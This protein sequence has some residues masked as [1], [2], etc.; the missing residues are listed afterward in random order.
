MFGAWTRPR[1][2]RCAKK[3][4]QQ[5]EPGGQNCPKCHPH[6]SFG[7]LRARTWGLSVA[8][9]EPFAKTLHAKGNLLASSWS[10]LF[11]FVIAVK[12]YRPLSMA[13][14]TMILTIVVRRRRRHE[15]DEDD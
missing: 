15:D 7:A 13:F 12:I 9:F 2:Q 6:P 14:E 1:L 5:K 10:S 11:V 4:E 8:G 3:I